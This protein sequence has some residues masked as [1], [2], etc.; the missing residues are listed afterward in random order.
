M[1]YL[2]LIAMPAL[3]NRAPICSYEADTSTPTITK[4]KSMS[5]PR[6]LARERDN[7]TG[8]IKAEGAEEAGFGYATAVRGWRRW[9]PL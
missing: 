2:T 6:A 8:V 9:Y 5:E 3:K 4:G 1:M 7:G